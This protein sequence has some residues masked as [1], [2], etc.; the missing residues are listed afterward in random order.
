ME[1][2]PDAVIQDRE[3]MMELAEVAARKQE[4]MK[5]SMQRWKAERDNNADY[6]AKL[7]QNKEERRKEIEAQEAVLQQMK[8]EEEAQEAAAAEE[9][10]MLQEQPQKEQKTEKAEADN[11]KKNFGDQQKKFKSKVDQEYE[12]ALNSVIKPFDVAALDEAQMKK[13]VEEL[14]DVFTNLINDKINLNKQLVEQDGTVR[15]LREKL[16]EILDARAAKKGQIDMHK[17]YPGKKSSHPPKMQIFSKYDNR[18][19]TRSYDER[20]EMYDEGIDVVRPKMLASVWAEKF[21]AWLS[22]N[23]EEQ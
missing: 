2:P 18:K 17:F 21:S 15:A 8:E 6:I 19:G 1:A 20:K 9:E 10:K 23:P 12:A 13:K 7:K 11:S 4:A 5:E 16:N 14:Y 22:E 3:M